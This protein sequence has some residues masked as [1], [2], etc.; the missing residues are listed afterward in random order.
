MK[1]LRW[2]VLPVTVVLVLAGCKSTVS[3]TDGGSPT[4]LRRPVI[5]F[6]GASNVH[7][8][9]LNVE[10]QVVLATGTLVASAARFDPVFLPLAQ[11]PWN[12][13]QPH[14]PVFFWD[15]EDYVCNVTVDPAELRSTGTFMFFQVDGG[16]VLALSTFD[17]LPAMFTGIM[18]VGSRFYW[19]ELVDRAAHIEGTCQS[20]DRPETVQYALD[21]APGWN[22]VAFVVTAADSDGIV[23]SLRLQ[24][25][26]PVPDAKWYYYGFSFDE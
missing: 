10:E 11:L 12:V 2:F 20:V 8:E 7:F 15:D 4:V 24:S 21:L 3:D 18:P 13:L 5:G 25:E 16:G 19:F 23:T 22:P 14:S 17:W 1:A 9:A 26:S 6:S